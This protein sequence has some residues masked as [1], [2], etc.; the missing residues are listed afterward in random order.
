MGKGAGCVGSEYGGG[1]HRLSLPSMLVGLGSLEFSC[2]AKNPLLLLMAPW[3]Q[4]SFLTR[5]RPFRG[6]YLADLPSIVPQEEVCLG[7]PSLDHS[8]Q[9]SKPSIFSQNSTSVASLAHLPLKSFPFSP[10]V[11]MFP[12]LLVLRKCHVSSGGG[13]ALQAL[14]RAR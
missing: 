13:G 5:R 2:C 12:F 3:C 14:S 4:S 11:Y 8:P 9:S 6:S 10:S 1:S 7:A